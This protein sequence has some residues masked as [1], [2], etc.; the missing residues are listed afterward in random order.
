VSAPL[1]V[2]GFGLNLLVDVAEDSLWLGP[3]LARK[4]SERMGFGASLFVIHDSTVLNEIFTQRIDSTGLRSSVAARAEI[5][6]WST[7]LVLGLQFRASEKWNLGFRVQSPSVDIRGRTDY[8]IV[9]HSNTAGQVVDDQNGTHSVFRRPFHFGIGNKFSPLPGADF[10]LD[11]NAQLPV[12]FNTALSRPQVNSHVDTNFRL[13]GNFGAKFRWGK[14]HTLLAG[15]LYNPSTL[16]TSGNL[17]V[18]NTSENFKGAM[19]G[20][21]KDLGPL[22]TSMGG[23]FLWSNATFKSP[24][25]G[26]LSEYAHRIYGLLLTA[27]YKL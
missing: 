6:N 25:T 17:D 22:V 2:P 26:R 5:S 7:L 12:H 27:S 24:D 21:Q 9:T 18:M 11:V 10:Y 1:T 19:L 20:V 23:F 13:R 14:T 3:S 4:I 16:P 8:F 15:F